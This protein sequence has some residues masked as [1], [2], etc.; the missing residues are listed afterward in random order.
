MRALPRLA[1]A[2]FVLSAVPAFAQAPKPA[3][4]APAATLEPAAGEEVME[5]RWIALAE[6][7]HD[8]FTMA[9]SKVAKDRDAAA[10]DLRKAV[11]VLELRAE[12][13]PAA[14][15]QG[16]TD[17]AR[18]VRQLERGLEQGTVRSAKQLS[19]PLARAEHALAQDHFQRAEQAWSSKE[20]ARAGHE[21]RLTAL[22]TDEAA[23]WS[24]QEAQR[25]VQASVRDTRKLADSLIEGGSK[26]AT[27]V[28]EGLAKAGRGVEQLAQWVKPGASQQQGTGGSAA[29]DA[30]KP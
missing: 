18:E 1:A 8:Y 30:P 2:L 17:A 27:D 7:P 11:A 26:G 13:A 5:D 20:E 4:K 25:A 3:A 29:P 14:S 23:R 6:V 22:Y 19:E 21:L 28:G 9:K 16:L 15:R 12:Q 10:K 24:G